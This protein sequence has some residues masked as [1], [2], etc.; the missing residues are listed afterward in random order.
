MLPS[1]VFSCDAPANDFPGAACF[2]YADEEACAADSSCAYC[3]TKV[4]HTLPSV[5]TPTVRNPSSA[6]AP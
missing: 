5:C 3:K 4:E 6:T 1:A 2:G